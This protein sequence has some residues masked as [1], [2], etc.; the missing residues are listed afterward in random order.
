MSGR[1]AGTES[2]G[3]ETMRTKLMG[4]AA[5]AGAVMAALLPASAQARGGLAAEPITTT[6]TA[7]ARPAPTA[8]RAAT[9][10]R[11][12]SCAAVADQQRR[13][14]TAA[15]VRT[16]CL[17]PETLPKP[18]P[19]HSTLDFQRIPDWCG[20]VQTGSWWSYRNESC[21]MQSWG[22]YVQ[23]WI[24]GRLTVI[25]YVAF[26]ELSYSYTSSSISTWGQQMQI[27]IYQALGDTAGLTLQG[28]ARCWGSCTMGNVNFP[29]QSAFAGVPGGEAFFNSTSTSPGAVGSANTAIDWYFTKPDTIS[30]PVNSSQPPVVRCDNDTPGVDVGCVSPDYTPVLIYAQ[31]GPYPE[32]ARHILDA[33]NSGLPGA[34]PN[35]TP[36]SRL[37]DQGLRDLN[38]DTACPDSYPR[39]D[40]KS[41]DEYPFASTWQGAWTGGGDPRTF[42]WCQISLP[43]PNS[44][45]SSGYSACMIDDGQ[46]SGG[47]GTLGYFYSSNRVISGDSFRVWIQ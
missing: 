25:G 18:T 4:V 11:T 28:S 30:S 45:G 47:G 37:V 19:G 1:P 24:E 8:L 27:S 12:D 10:A 2:S 43:Q 23:A 22:L 15:T 13:H 29:A 46:N 40:G 16:V 34:Y 38:R 26:W 14:P 39:P 3:E 5:L 6:S 17:Q 44:T 21:M 42:D 31:S 9:T 41:C 36:L 7:T 35:G 33:Q 20:T 32:L